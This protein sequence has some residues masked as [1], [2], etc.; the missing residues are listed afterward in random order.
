VD[1]EE[2]RQRVSRNATTARNLVKTGAAQPHPASLDESAVSDVQA[3]HFRH[4]TTA[5]CP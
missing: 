3:S 2:V 1:T 4:E 5:F